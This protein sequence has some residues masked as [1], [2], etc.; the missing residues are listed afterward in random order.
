MEWFIL[1]KTYNFLLF[2]VHFFN[3][4]LIKSFSLDSSDLI[5]QLLSERV[6]PNWNSLL[7]SMRSQN[8]VSS[9]FHALRHQ[10]SNF[11]FWNKFFSSSTFFLWHQWCWCN[12]AIYSRAVDKL[13]AKKRKKEK[14]TEK[15]TLHI[16][17]WNRC[18]HKKKW[19]FPRRLWVIRKLLNEFPKCSL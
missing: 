18:S 19:V 4:F 1:L 8:P 6:V 17:I 12:A 11:Y 7:R 13:F 14:E 9:R 2:L 10:K 5:S 15:I 3:N 16:F